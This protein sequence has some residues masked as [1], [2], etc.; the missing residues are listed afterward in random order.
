[1]KII[2]ILCRQN[3]DTSCG[4]QF[5]NRIKADEGYSGTNPFI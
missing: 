4:H 2:T 5:T 1:M 3:I